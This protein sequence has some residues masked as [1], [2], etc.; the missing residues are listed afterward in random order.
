MGLDFAGTYTQVEESRLIEYA[1]GKR[2]AR[3]EFAQTLA[4][5]TVRVTFDAESRHSV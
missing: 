4:G 1:F 3:A 5:V 2:R